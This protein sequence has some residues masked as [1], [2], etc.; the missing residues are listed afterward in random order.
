MGRSFVRGA[1]AE[2]MLE[3]LEDKLAELS[4]TQNINSATSEDMLNAFEDKLDEFEDIETATAINSAEELFIADSDDSE[5]YE[6]PDMMFGDG[7][8]V[9]L[10]DIKRYWINNYNDDPSLNEGYAPSE[11]DKWVRDTLRWLKPI[12]DCTGINAADD[13]GEQF[14][15]M[16]YSSDAEAGI[17]GDEFGCMGKFYAP[18]YDEALAQFDEI[19]NK[20]PERFGDRNTKFTH[21]SYYVDK[22]SDYFDDGSPVYSDLNAL[23]ADI[24]SSSDRDLAY[25]YGEEPFN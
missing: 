14:M 8:P 22:Y 15:L 20:Y 16:A 1:S 23:V 9:S 11:G 6:D 3:A 21:S 5:L 10:A 4:G 2:R 17:E 18:S 19:R 12:E 24:L 13:I 7:G 25:E